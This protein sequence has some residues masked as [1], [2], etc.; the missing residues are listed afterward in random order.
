MQLL[1]ITYQREFNQNVCRLFLKDKIKILKIKIKMR[2]FLLVLNMDVCVTLLVL[3]NWERGL[4]SLKGHMQ[5]PEIRKFCRQTIRDS[6]DLEFH[7]KLRVLWWTPSFRRLRTRVQ[8]CII[9]PVFQQ[10]RVFHK[11]FWTKTPELYHL[12]SSRE[13][14]STSLYELKIPVLYHLCFSR[15]ECSTSLSEQTI[16]VLYHL[17]SSREECPTS[18]SEQTIPVLYHL[19]SSREECPTNFLNKQYQYYTTCVPAGKSV[20][21]PRQFLQI[22]KH[23]YRTGL[24]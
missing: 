10:V 5:W 11:P 18:L 15:E 17:C 6:T 1:L 16:P 9:P 23:R 13:E 8:Y 14:C 20:P 21:Q 7:S 19:C 12:C 22:N 24:D 4:C 3:R 2:A